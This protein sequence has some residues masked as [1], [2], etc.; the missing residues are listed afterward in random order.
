MTAGSGGWCTTAGSSVAWRA[1]R[2]RL[3]RVA[4]GEIPVGHCHERWD[5]GRLGL[6][7]VSRSASVKSLRNVPD[8]SYLRANWANAPICS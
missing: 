6:Q 7:T 3:V 2:P 1:G 8:G 5:F 4:H